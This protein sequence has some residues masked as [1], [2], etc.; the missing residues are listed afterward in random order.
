MK[1]FAGADP[2]GLFE[3]SWYRLR[4][5]AG[6]R[7]PAAAGVISD[8]LRIKAAEENEM[9]YKAML[10][11]WASTQPHMT[12]WDTGAATSD[13]AAPGHQTTRRGGACAGQ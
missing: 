8:A 1:G 12:E 4:L 7:N 6:L 9:A 3:Q 13:G 2:Y 10:T 5:A 11:A